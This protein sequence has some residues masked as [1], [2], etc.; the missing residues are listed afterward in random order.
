MK[1]FLLS[2]I[3]IIVSFCLVACSFTE[4]HAGF[5]LGL[6]YLKTVDEMEETSGFDSNAL[7]FLGVYSF[8]PSLINFELDFEVVPNYAL[9]K[10]L[11][12]GS[13]FAFVGSTLYGGL[14]I[15]M[16]HFDGEMSENPFFDLRAGFKIS[17]FDLFASYRMQD[18][19]EVEE[20]ES[21]DLNSVTFGAIFKF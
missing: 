5:G 16:S 4:S 14:G 20:L 12:Q 19:D 8:G 17:R 11:Y 2:L 3:I 18:L 15:G 10:N 7:G 9:D 13:A 6:H 21:N 1:R